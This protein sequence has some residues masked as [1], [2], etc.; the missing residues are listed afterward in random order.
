MKPILTTT[1]CLL[2][3]TVVCANISNDDLSRSNLDEHAL[4]Q[5]A[6]LE[7][8]INPVGD[9]SPSMYGIAGAAA[10]ALL[11]SNRRQKA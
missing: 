1:A 10:M 6:A 3:A 11:I 4:V 7:A 9:F 5:A 2:V 8:S